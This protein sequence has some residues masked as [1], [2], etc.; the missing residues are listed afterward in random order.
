MSA[1][2]IHAKD[3]NTNKSGL[4]TEPWVPLLTMHSFCLSVQ[5]HVSHE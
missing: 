2:L 1:T 5:G 3:A 4:K